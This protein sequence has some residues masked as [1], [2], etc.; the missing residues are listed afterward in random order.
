[1]KIFVINLDRATDRWSYFKD[2][3]RFIRWSATDYSDLNDNNP[4]FKDMVSYW[5]ISPQEHRAKCGCY[6]SHTNL[7]RYIVQ[8]K[9]NDI[10]IIED[11]AEL[12]GEIPDSS[13][14]PQ[15]GFTYLGGLTFN[16]KITQ[17]PKKVE[18]NEGINQI[19][20]DD[21]RVLTTL[22]I[23]IPNWS[24]AY[25]MLQATTERGRP[26]AIDT[27]VYKTETNQYLYYPAPFIE[28]NIPSQIRKKKPKHSNEFYEW[29]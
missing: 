14:L 3:E 26:R 22:A 9:L 24:V 6:L 16:K 12:V 28:R 20:D 11:D 29:V 1:M 18:L 23:Y 7:W 4:I 2:D 5:N 25:K 19:K 27:M 8:N 13:K 10:L 21:Y 17:G 15:D